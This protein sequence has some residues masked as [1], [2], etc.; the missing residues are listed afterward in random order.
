MSMMSAWKAQR[1]VWAPLSVAQREG[2][3]FDVL[4]DDRLTLPE[5]SQRIADGLGINRVLLDGWLGSAARRMVKRGQ[6]DRV[7][8]KG[9]AARHRYFRPRPLE[10]TIADLE[11]AYHAGTGEEA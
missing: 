6:L 2:L 9:G 4:G 5:L 10:G 1:E 11:R 7:A 3:L 8:I